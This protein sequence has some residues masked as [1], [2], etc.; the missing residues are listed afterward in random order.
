[1][2]KARH[3]TRDFGNIYR[4]IFREKQCSRQQ[5]SEQLGISLPTVT[6]SLNLLKE[7]NL[8]HISGTYK[9]SGGRKANIFECV[10]NARYAVGIDITRNHL[11][12]ALINL[13]LEIIGNIRIRCPFQDTTSYYENMC[14]ELEKLLDLHSIDKEKLLGV[15]ISLPVIIEPDNKTISY[16]TVINISRNVYQH[17]S[18]RL[19]NPFLLFN[20]AS[21]A[22][23]AESWTHQ[24][25]K[26][27][28][29]L[30]LSGSVGGAFMNTDTLFAGDN[31]KA[32]EFGHICIVPHGRQCYCGCHGCVDA[33]CS[34]KV[35]SDF[36][37]GNLEDFFE[38]LK[39]G[40][41]GFMNIFDEYLD[42]L[43]I[44]VNNLRM[45]YDCDV[46]IGGTVGAHMNDYID[47]LRAKAI[48]LNPFEKNSDYIKC[49]HYKTAA[50]AV[51]AAIYFINEFVN[52]L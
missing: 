9:S 30:S 2:Q 49:C 6:Q 29:Y 1:M 27:S 47:I 5:I 11:N 42:Y 50:S 34:A 23:L 32:S 16:A 7:M 33:Y 31:N 22:G 15:G 21:S 3:K 19:Q 38:D 48:A 28:A 40:N 35:L 39:N 4:F 10:P 12:I 43:A 52:D 17:I 18:T 44:A 26:P 51:G 25:D 14:T 37:N 8:I 24:S 20:D 41:K 46:I 13:K 45:C 36:T